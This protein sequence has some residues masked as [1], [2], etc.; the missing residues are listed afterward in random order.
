MRVEAMHNGLPPILWGVLAIGGIATILFTFF[1]GGNLRIQVIM[2]GLIA[3]LIGL[4][5]FLL[6]SYDDPFSGDVM[7][8]NDAFVVD[9]RIFRV[10]TDKND[11]YEMDQ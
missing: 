8:G 3:V 9:Q 2:T 1:F 10:Q 4:N 11:P 7:V 6:A 5:I